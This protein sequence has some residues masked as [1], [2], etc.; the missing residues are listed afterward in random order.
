MYDICVKSGSYPDQ[1]DCKESFTKVL[2][3]EH[4][5][6]SSVDD[7]H[8]KIVGIVKAFAEKSGQLI[9]EDV[10]A[11]SKVKTDENGDITW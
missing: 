1:D 3:G 10:K 6:V 9:V 7:I 11:D 4:V 2:G 8:K 5:I